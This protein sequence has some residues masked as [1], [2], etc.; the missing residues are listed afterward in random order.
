MEQCK[1]ERPIAGF[2]KLSRRDIEAREAW[3]TSEQ[4]GILNLIRRRKRNLALMHPGE[5]IELQ[6]LEPLGMSPSQLAT[7]LRS[8]G[9]LEVLRRKRGITADLALRLGKL[10]HT[11]A[12]YWMK[13]QA[14]YDL[15]LAASSVRHGEIKPMKKT[16]SEI[17]LN[18][19]QPRASRY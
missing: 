15:R 9:I 12:E 8:R 6:Y 18:A 13:V 11:S 4:R 5:F 2:S 16:G 14:N 1:K 17:S 3:I 7:R 10:F 19:Q